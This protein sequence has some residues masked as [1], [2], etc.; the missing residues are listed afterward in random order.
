[1]N[2]KFLSLTS[3]TLKGV[4]MSGQFSGTNKRQ[5]N[6]KMALIMGMMALIGIIFIFYLRGYLR[7]FIFRQVWRR[8][9]CR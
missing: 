6:G 4:W 7:L 9:L 3:V 2:S 5:K 1:M 8:R